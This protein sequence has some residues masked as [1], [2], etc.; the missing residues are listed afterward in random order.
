ME[1]SS[2]LGVSKILTRA[3]TFLRLRTS[4]SQLAQSDNR[5]LHT[6]LIAMT[7]RIRIKRRSVSKF[8]ALSEI[9][10]NSALKHDNNVAMN[11]GAFFPRTSIIGIR[12][13]G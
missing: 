13:I 12:S 10:D 2:K 5:V 6:P 9:D 11:S 3:K 7:L 1:T 4:H 8:K